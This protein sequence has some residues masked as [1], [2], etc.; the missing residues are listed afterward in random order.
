ME[1][2][3]I[4]DPRVAYAVGA[5]GPGL[6]LK[7]FDGGITWSPQVSNTAQR[8]KDVWFVDER[9]G[10]AVGAAGRILHTSNGGN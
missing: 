5:N 3:Q 1:S 4:V 2:V 7:S 9:R 8:L 6:V 10:W